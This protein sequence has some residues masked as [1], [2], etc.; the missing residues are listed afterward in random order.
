M[1]SLTTVLTWGAFALSSRTC[2]ELDEIN[3]QFTWSPN[4]E[5]YNNNNNKDGLRPFF[6]GDN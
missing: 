6:G 3:R 2:N 1:E 4:C 5:K